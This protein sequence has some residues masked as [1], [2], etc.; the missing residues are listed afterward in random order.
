MPCTQVVQAIAC[1]RVVLERTEPRDV[2]TLEVVRFWPMED[3]I[4]TSTELEQ[5]SEDVS[6][7][8]STK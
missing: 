3:W 2:I 7:L 8:L 4:V 1:S 6:L 5:N